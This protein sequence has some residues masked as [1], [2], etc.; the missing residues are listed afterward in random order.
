MSVVR[1]S[2]SSVGRRGSWSVPSHLDVRAF[3]GN[4]ELDLRDAVMEPGTTTIDVGVTMASVE[5]IVPPE[6]PV[7]SEIEGFAASV[8]DRALT[9]S[10]AAG[11]ERRLR[12]TGKVRFGNCEVVV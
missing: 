7:D 11:G 2:L 6:L 12:L 1:A 10:K 4:V 8:C 5:I 3:W 9:D